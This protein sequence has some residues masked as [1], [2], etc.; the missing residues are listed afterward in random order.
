VEAI[1]ALD[2]VTTTVCGCKLGGGGVH[3]LLE[4]VCVSRHRVEHRWSH[5]LPIAR[6]CE[7]IW[8]VSHPAGRLSSPAPGGLGK[9]WRIH[10]NVPPYADNAHGTGLTVRLEPVVFA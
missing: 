10:A 4:T 7:Y 8:G 6:L 9:I 5:S 1:D 2:D 3:A